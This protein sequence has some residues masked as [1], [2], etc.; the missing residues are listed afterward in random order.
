M[1]YKEFIGRPI[2]SVH[3]YEKGKILGIN[4]THTIVSFIKEEEPLALT[5]EQFLIHCLCD[6]ETKNV[7]EELKRKQDERV[8]SLRQIGSNQEND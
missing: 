5:H 8:N 1:K 4:E 7:I 3:T 2:R 6:E